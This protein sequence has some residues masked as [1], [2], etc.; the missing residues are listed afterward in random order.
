MHDINCSAGA[1]TFYLHHNY[2]DR[3]WWQW[4]QANSSSRMYDISGNTLN[5]TYLEEEGLTAPIG[6][7][8]NITL[9]YALNVQDMLP[10]VKIGEIMNVHG[11]YLCYEYDY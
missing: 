10:D 4:Q 11:G 1:P 7:Y 8:A 3:L 2:I 5:E 6:G 9:D